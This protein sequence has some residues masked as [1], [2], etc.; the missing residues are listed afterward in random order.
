MICRV[1]IQPFLSVI[2]RPVFNP[3]VYVVSE[4]VRATVFITHSPRKRGNQVGGKDQ[5][6]PC[7]CVGPNLVLE[8]SQGSCVWL[9]HC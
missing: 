9:R 1:V 8:K 2:E 5:I 4:G 7:V 3:N 6:C